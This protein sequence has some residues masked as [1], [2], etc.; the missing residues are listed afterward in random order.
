[1]GKGICAVSADAERGLLT[2]GAGAPLSSAAREAASA[3]LSG[4]ESVSGI[5]GTV[6]GALYM[7]AGSYG[8]DMSM[9]VAGARVYDPAC[10]EAREMGPGDMGFGYR[11]SAFQDSG[12]LILSATFRLSPGEPAAIR[13]AM[14]EYAAMR[15][16]K[17][18]LNE[19]SAGSFFK[20]PEGA[21][22]GALIERAGLKGMSVGGARVSDKHAGFIVNTGGATAADVL[23]LMKAV[24]D[25][26]KESS[27]YALEPEPRII[28]EDI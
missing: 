13:E 24:Q 14:R 23:G 9:V 5:P 12:L 28:G 10:G 1:L 8:G 2:A 11:S 27:G 6:G 25:A 19:A 18:P 15:S 22:A 16:A 26:V 21:Y 20:R 3:G 17:Q 7:N 4:L